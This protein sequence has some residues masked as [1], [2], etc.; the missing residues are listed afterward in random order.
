[1]SQRGS[2]RCRPAPPDA[3]RRPA[4]PTARWP[5]ATRARFFWWAIAA[6]FLWWATLALTS[7]FFMLLGRVPKPH[8]LFHRSQSRCRVPKP[9]WAVTVTQS[10]W[11]HPSQ[12]HRWG[13]PPPLGDT[14]NSLRCPLMF[15]RWW[16]SVVISML[17]LFWHLTLFRL[18]I[19]L[20]I[21]FYLPKLQI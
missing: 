15:E 19:N 17:G 4:P 1:V 16:F 8:F 11:C 5:S 12:D 10:C 21:C 7:F 14:D 18:L 9:R 2:V 13:V 6:P 20:G 3:A